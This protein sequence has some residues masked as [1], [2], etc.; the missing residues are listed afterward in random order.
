[1][2]SPRCRYVPDIPLPSY[3]YVPGRHPHP[4][5]DPAG[6]SFGAPKPSFPPLD[7][8]RWATS[9]PYLYGIDLFNHGYYWE[10]HEVWEGLWR[11]HGRTETIALFFKGLIA[12]AAAGVKY[13]QGRPIGVQRHAER[14][15]DCFGQVAQQLDHR[16]E[17]LGLELDKLIRY[18]TALAQGTAP[19][20]NPLA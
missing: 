17:Y 1:M 8:E 9:R 14:A 2:S 19:D 3:A 11:A 7:P 20:Q 4:T 18:A 10:A 5:R 6:H 15:R 13:R 16:P 12:L